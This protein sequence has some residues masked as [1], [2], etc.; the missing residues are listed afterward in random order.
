MYVLNIKVECCGITQKTA[1]WKQN[2]AK[3]IAGVAGRV[4]MSLKKRL[5]KRN[6]SPVVFD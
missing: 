5:L 3:R 6:G 1:E 2:N 4:G